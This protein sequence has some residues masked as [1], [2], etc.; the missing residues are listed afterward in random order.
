MNKK[1]VRTCMMGLAV[2]MLLATPMLLHPRRALALDPGDILKQMGKTC[3]AGIVTENVLADPADKL[4]NGIL[5]QGGLSTSLATR[6]VPIVAVGQ[7]TRADRGAGDGTCR[8]G[9]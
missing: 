3:A 1:T 6:V 4:L 8:S 7:G 9:G 2:L 5:M